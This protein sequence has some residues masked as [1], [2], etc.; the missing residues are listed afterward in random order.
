MNFSGSNVFLNADYRNKVLLVLDGTG[1][2]FAYDYDPDEDVQPVPDPV[3]PGNPSS[4]IWIIVGSVF[5]GVIILTLVLMYVFR[6][7]LP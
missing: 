7:K 1:K 6:A 4:L 5:A 2:V 3:N